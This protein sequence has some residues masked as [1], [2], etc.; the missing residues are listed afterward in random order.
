METDSL[1]T[2]DPS[3]RRT[4]AA[5]GTACLLLGFL[6]AAVVLT[7]RL[8]ADWGHLGSVIARNP[9]LCWGMSIGLML[10]GIALIKQASHDEMDWAPALRGPRF[11][12]AVLYIR[13]ECPLCDEAVRTLKPYRPYLPRIAKVDVD[14]D[15]EL[16]ERFGT[17]VPVL[18]LDGRVRFRGHV[19]ETLLRRL[20]EGSPPARG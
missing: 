1:D 6:L 19:N 13:S 3:F 18:E 11:R 8:N 2:S 15:S 4:P 5:V 16:K 17:C 10:G 9:V 14:N 12:Q 7:V 20:I